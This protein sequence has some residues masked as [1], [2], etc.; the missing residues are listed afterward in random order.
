MRTYLCGTIYY[1]NHVF[2]TNSSPMLL[3][4]EYGKRGF[5]IRWLLRIQCARMGIHSYLFKKIFHIDSIFTFY[6]FFFILKKYNFVCLIH[7]LY[8]D[9]IFTFT[10]SK[11]AFFLTIVAHNT[12]RMCGSALIRTFLSYRQHSHISFIFKKFLFPT[13]LKLIIRCALNR[14]ILSG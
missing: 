12:M 8:I 5:Y 4:R 7:F 11:S 2:I 13:R 14:T 1:K 3:Y 9:S 10:L 6:D